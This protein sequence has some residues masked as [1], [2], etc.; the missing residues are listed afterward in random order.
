VNVRRIAALLR[1]L[2]DAIEQDDEQPRLR[3]TKA[4][5]LDP[6]APKPSAAMTDRVRRNLRRQGVVA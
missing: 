3:R 4:V 2:A 5:R 1:E 6:D